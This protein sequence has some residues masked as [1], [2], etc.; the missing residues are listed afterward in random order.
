[1]LTTIYLLIGGKPE[2]AP[3]TRGVGFYNVYIYIYIYNC[4]YYMFVSDYFSE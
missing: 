2:R 1:M 4:V 3:N